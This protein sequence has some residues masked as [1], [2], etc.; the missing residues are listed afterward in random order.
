MHAF[1]VSGRY[2]HFVKV[3]KTLKNV[4]YETE[5]PVVKIGEV[6]GQLFEQN[7]CQASLAVT[8]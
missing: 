8:Q 1:F 4:K 6:R 5:Q 7:I 3:K 2:V